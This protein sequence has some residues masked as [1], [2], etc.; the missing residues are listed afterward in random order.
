MRKTL[1]NVEILSA[2]KTLDRVLATAD[3]LPGGPV[4]VPLAR[5][6]H[7]LQRL[8]A[9]VEAARGDVV[10]RHAVRGDDGEPVGTPVEGTPGALAYE[11]ADPEAAQA[12]I[13]ELMSA[14]VEAELYPPD[15]SHA[16]L[17]TLDAADL[18]ALLDLFEGPLP[19]PAAPPPAAPDALAPTATP[20]AA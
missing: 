8:A 18:M 16:G 4:Q 20:A 11:L 6:L 10:R 7:A 9:P 1:S 5:T 15:L 3:G 13:H 12:E 14:C 19:V 17:P 2:A